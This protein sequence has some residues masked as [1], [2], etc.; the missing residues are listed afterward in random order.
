M[1][2]NCLRR[3]R[4]R[5]AKMHSGSCTNGPR[6]EGSS[7]GLIPTRRFGMGRGP[8]T[9]G[10]WRL[11]CRMR[12]CERARTRFALSSTVQTGECRRRAGRANPSVAPAPMITSVRGRQRSQ[13]RIQL[14]VRLAH[15]QG[16]VWRRLRVRR[17]TIPMAKA[18]RI[19]EMT[20]PKA[21]NDI[22][23]TPTWEPR[24]TA[25]V[26][27][28]RCHRECPPNDLPISSDG[29]AEPAA[30]FYADA[31]A[32]TTSAATACWTAFRLLLTDGVSIL[33]SSPYWRMPRS[34]RRS[35]SS[36]RRASRKLEADVLSKRNL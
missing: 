23:T 6:T 16:S 18:P 19:R 33:R 21:T 2:T 31:L 1:G 4:G 17:M 11:W 25:G 36:P 26:L 7:L 8:T 3:R 12:G 14:L 27:E 9:T 5:R 22:D 13:H 29:A 24:S 20:S 35:T 34:N 28:D 30:R 15:V 32:A 10:R